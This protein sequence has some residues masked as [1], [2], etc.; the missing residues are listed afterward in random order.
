MVCLYNSISHIHEYHA[1]NIQDSD[2]LP[3]KKGEIL[4]IVNKDEE[5]WWT[6]R[7]SQGQTGQIPVP[8]IEL[9]SL[10]SHEIHFKIT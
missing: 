7:N 4:Y 2:D 3:F 9:V 6:A 10:F 1:Y 5:Q 8:Y